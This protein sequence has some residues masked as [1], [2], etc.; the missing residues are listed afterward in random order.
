M[1]Q[2]INTKRQ[3]AALLDSVNDGKIGQVMSFQ[4]NIVDESSQ[5]SIIDVTYIFQRTQKKCG[6]F[7]QLVIW[8]GKMS[9]CNI[10]DK[11]L[12][13]LVL[14]KTMYDDTL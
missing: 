13:H 11:N 7:I 4:M 5:N 12:D 6:I 2:K 3:V 8:T 1:N 9:L 14:P 10:S